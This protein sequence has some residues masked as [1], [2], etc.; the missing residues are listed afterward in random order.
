MKKRK[1]RVLGVMTIS[2]H[3]DVEATS[4]DEARAAAEC[5]GEA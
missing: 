5:S 3:I 4:E 1:Y 2:V